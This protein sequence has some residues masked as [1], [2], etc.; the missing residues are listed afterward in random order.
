[1]KTDYCFLISRADWGLAYNGHLRFLGT[2]N[3]RSCLAKRTDRQNGEKKGPGMDLVSFQI[4]STLCTEYQCAHQTAFHRCCCWNCQFLFR[5]Q[6]SFGAYLRRCI[7]M[8]KMS[9]NYYLQDHFS[10]SCRAAQLTL[11]LTYNAHVSVYV[12]SVG[13]YDELSIGR[14]SAADREKQRAISLNASHDPT[15]SELS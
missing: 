10:L 2:C 3:P 13:T 11:L 7:Y 9:I 5:V 4:P 12:R 1:M 6:S 8:I 15:L 14:T